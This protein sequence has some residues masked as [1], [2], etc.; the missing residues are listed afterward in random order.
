MRLWWIGLAALL[1][2]GCVLVPAPV[3]YGY[4][5]APPRRVIY[6]PPAY[7]RPYYHAPYRHW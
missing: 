4:V 6:G 3:P 1:L 7:P 2:G 5:P